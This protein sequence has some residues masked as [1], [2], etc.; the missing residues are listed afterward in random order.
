LKALIIEDNREISS[1]IKQG[2][3]YENFLVDTAENGET[4]LQKAIVNN[5]D[6]IILDLL[7]PKMDGT[8]LIKRFREK[9]HE[10][11]IIVVTAVHDQENKIRLLNLGADDYIEKPFSFMELITRIRVILRRM[12]HSKNTGIIKINDLIINPVS[13]E[14]RRSGKLIK[15]RNKEFMLLE[16]L[17][18]HRGEAVNHAVILENVWDFNS[19]SLSNTIGTHMSN[20]RKKIDHG[21]KKQLIQTIHGFGYKIA[22]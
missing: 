20:L 8:E 16:Y 11:P 4:G 22:K 15:L 17:V 7:L 21:F 6:V 12:S 14:V 19:S 5:Y 13:R 3:Q 2:L 18:Q 10:T 1:F 9:K